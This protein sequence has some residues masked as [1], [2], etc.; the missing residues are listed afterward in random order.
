[1]GVPVSRMER[2]SPASALLS[3]KVADW[4][5][6]TPP[7]TWYDCDVQEGSARLP[8]VSPPPRRVWTLASVSSPTTRRP[9]ASAQVRHGGKW[10]EKCWPLW[11]IFSENW[12]GARCEV[13]RLRCTPGDR[14]G[15]CGKHGEC[16]HDRQ[17]G[18]YHCACHL[19]WKGEE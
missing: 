1:M 13:S 9:T 18:L 8:G 5:V 12:S 14:T 17:A 2:P 16:R 10:K 3:I 15:P 7:A 11:N 4:S 19:W 6:I